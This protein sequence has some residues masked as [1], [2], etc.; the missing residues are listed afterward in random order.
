[1]DDPALAHALGVARQQLA[2]LECGDTDAYIGGLDE[3]AAACAAL[4]APLSSGINEL[5]DIDNRMGILLQRAKDD[6]GLRLASIHRRR[7]VTG[8][9]FAPA[10]ITSRIVA[11]G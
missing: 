8:A 7:R 6:V 10:S 1:M 2:R 11:Q 9:Y 5:V 4:R 3:Y